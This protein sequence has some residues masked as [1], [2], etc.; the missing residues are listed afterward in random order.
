MTKETSEESLR[1]T[2][3]LGR[4]IERVSPV[5]VKPL[6]DQGNEGYV[7]GSGVLAP[8]PGKHTHPRVGQ[9]RTAT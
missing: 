5:Q 2:G 8:H 6:R 1:I 4:K 3:L 7:D 9:N